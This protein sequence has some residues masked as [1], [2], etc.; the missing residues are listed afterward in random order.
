MADNYLLA[1]LFKRFADHGKTLSQCGC[2][3]PLEFVTELQKERYLYDADEQKRVLQAF[4]DNS[5]NNI[6][7][8]AIYEEI[9]SAVD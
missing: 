1:D 3:E 9:V 2:P 6:E 4:Q 7:Q 5:P 8:Q